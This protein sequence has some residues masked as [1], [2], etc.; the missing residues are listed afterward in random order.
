MERLQGLGVHDRYVI[1]VERIVDEHLP[2]HVDGVV[3]AHRGRQ[4]VNPVLSEEVGRCLEVTRQRWC[5]PLDVNEYE[6]LPDVES[7]RTQTHLFLVDL[8]AETSPI[9]YGA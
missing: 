2:I 4:F 1:V 5:R 9:G 8:V 7:Q 6:T 3:D